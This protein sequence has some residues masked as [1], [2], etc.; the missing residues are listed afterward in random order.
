MTS[1]F[2]QAFWMFLLAGLGE[3]GGN[4]SATKNMIV[5]S[6]MLYS[7]FYNVSA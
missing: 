5:A 6:F 3:R 2:L 4:T 7:F 1:Y